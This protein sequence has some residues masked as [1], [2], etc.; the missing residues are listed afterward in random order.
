MKSNALIVIL[1]ST[2]FV[3]LGVWAYFAELDQ[4]VR[5][6]GTIQPQGDVHRVQSRFP[7]EIDEVLV[8]LGQQVAQGQTLFV[9]KPEE[10]EQQ[11]IKLLDRFQRT[12]AKV[13]R[14]TRQ[15]LYPLPS[16]DIPFAADIPI[17]IM[18][19]ELLALRTEYT[20]LQLQLDTVQSEISETLISISELQAQQIH[21]QAMANIAQQER[22]ILEPLV[23]EG[24][25]PK[26]KLSQ[27]DREI[28]TARFQQAEA[29]L[30]E[31]RL[32]QKIKSLEIRA[33]QLKSDYLI[34]IQTKLRDEQLILSETLND[35]QAATERLSQTQIRAPIAGIVSKVEDVTPGAIYRAGDLVAELVPLDEG[36]VAN[37]KLSPRDRPDVRPGQ[38]VRIAL[39]AYD[40]ATH[41]HL[42]GTIAQIAENTTST[43]NDTF[44]EVRVDLAS[45]QMT[46]TKII[47]ALRPGMTVQ[48]EVLGEKKTI[49][50]YVLNPILK[51]RSQALTD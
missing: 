42:L 41:G 51:I 27:L 33:N 8:T 3:L 44:Y 12:Q 50:E 34:G 25:E 23:I 32:R 2:V 17:E 39:D 45:R 11:R 40:F 7:G 49:L 36:F 29:Q 5:A 46:K 20:N 10:N 31:S 14:L 30:T 24:L 35:L 16:F 48:A 22:T 6:P 43:E 18:Q 19:S 15:L 13:D 37:V 38:D 21:Q 28:E 47:A 26:L 9:L 4:V 1:I